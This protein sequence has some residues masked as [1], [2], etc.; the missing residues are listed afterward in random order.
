VRLD[1]R[2]V[3]FNYSIVLSGTVHVLKVGF[4]PE[5][6]RFGPGTILTREAIARACEQGMRRYDFLGDE[7]AY[8]LDW[9]SE[10]TER[11][12]VQVFGRNGRGVAGFVA[13]RYGRPT[14]KRAMA[15]LRERTAGTEG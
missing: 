2:A 7:D 12:R 13:W 4:D 9:T 3:A 5:F 14:A 11:V 10:V 15:A 1:G 8:K 6:R